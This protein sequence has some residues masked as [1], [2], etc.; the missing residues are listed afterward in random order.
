MH[1]SNFLRF[2]PTRGYLGE[3][4]GLGGLSNLKLLDFAVVVVVVVRRFFVAVHRRFIVAVFGQGGL[5]GANGGSRPSMD[6]L[7]SPTKMKTF[8]A[9]KYL[10][11]YS[12]NK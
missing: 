2:A 5:F 10:S 12:T 7:A 11:I 4:R 9:I 8:W 3:L 1:G 6:G